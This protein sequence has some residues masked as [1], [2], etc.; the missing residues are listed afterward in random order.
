MCGERLDEAF[1][2]FSGIYGDRIYAFLS[3]TAPASFPFFT[4]REQEQMLL[5]RPRFRQTGSMRQPLNLTEAES[6]GSGVTS[7]YATPA[8]QAL[9][10]ETPGGKTYSIDDPALIERL[11]D[12]LGERHELTLRHSDRALTDCRPVSMFGVWSARQLSDEVGVPVDQRRFRANIYIDLASQKGFGED[13]LVGK[14]VRIG[15]KTVVAILQRDGRCKMITLDPD[16]AEQNPG[17]M[18]CVKERHEGMAGV[19]GAVLVEG[20]I[21]PG[22]EVALLD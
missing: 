19:Y 22:D 15:N 6:L 20:T 11:R 18:R 12:G 16:T 5:Y 4:G 3:S 8:D 10:I 7:I 21:R 14:T 1:A 13:E 17:V 9:D 2:G